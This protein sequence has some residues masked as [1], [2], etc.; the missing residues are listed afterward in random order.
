MNSER[1]SPD[2]PPAAAASATASL[3]QSARRISRGDAEHLA[4][5]RRELMWK[6][7]RSRAETL[8]ISRRDAENSRGKRGRSRAETLSISRTD[9]E[10]A[11]GKRGDL[12]RRR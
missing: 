8:S 10:N 2:H 12:A 4:Q 9:A 5:R 7:G 3:S 11:R 1:P 6:R